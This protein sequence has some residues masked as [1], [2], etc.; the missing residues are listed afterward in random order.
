MS[1]PQPHALLQPSDKIHLIIRRNFDGDIRRHFIGEI[2]RTAEATLLA[3]GFVF[4]F[5]T[6]TNNYIRRPDRRTRVFRSATPTTSSTS[7]R[8]APTS[9]PPIMGS[10]PTEGSSSPTA[11]LS[12]S[13]STNSGCSFRIAITWCRCSCNLPPDLRGGNIGGGSWMVHLAPLLSPRRAGGR[14]KMICTS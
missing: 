5:E 13:T 7:C 12:P 3:R 6:G 2:V 8:P 9:M 10:P 4:V 1:P 11:R 14:D